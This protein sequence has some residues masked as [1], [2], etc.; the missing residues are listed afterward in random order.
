MFTLFKLNYVGLGVLLA[1][2]ALSLPA[3]ADDLAEN[4][5]P[6]GPHE[7]ILATVGGKRVIAFYEP[8]SGQCGMHVVVW[9]SADVSGASAARVRVSL[10]PRQVVH[11]D[12]ADNKSIDLRCGDYADTLSLIERSTVVTAK[13]T[14]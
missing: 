6:V 1:L 7:P 8:R 2:S 9:N 12:S 3:R 14:R 10:D 5:G 13:S 4:L 11:I